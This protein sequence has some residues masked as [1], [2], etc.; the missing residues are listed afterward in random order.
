MALL[1]VVGM[2]A[3]N[4]VSRLPNLGQSL[5]DQGIHGFNGALVGCAA[6]VLSESSS[7]FDAALMAIFVA[8]GGGLTTVMIELWR[9]RFHRRGDPP[10]LTLP[11][12]LTTWGLMVLVSPRIPDSIETV[13]AAASTS[14][15]Q[16]L[17]LGI[18]HSFGQ[19]FLCSDL[20]SGWLVLLAVAVASPMAAA[21]GTCGALIGMITALASGT[22]PAAIAQGLWGYNGVLV[23]IALGGIFHAPGRR[24]LVIALIG[25]SLASLLQAMQGSWIGN[26]PPLTLSFVLTTWM[27]QGLAGPALP[28]LIPVALHAV[29]TTEE[30]RKR[31]LV[32]NELLGSFRQN[33]KQRIE[34]TLPSVGLEQPETERNSQMQHL[35]DQL[36]RNR[37][38]NLSLEELRHALAM[39]GASDGNQLRRTSSLNDQLAATMA[40]MDLNADGRINCNEFS[41]L[42]Q[43]L[44]RLR[45]GEERLLLYLM[46]VDT[47]GNDRLDHDELDRLLTSIGQPAL[48]SKEQALVFM[49]HE[50]SLSW[51]DF[52][53]RLLL[54]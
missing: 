20:A 18:P 50:Q 11:F 13:Q 46:P 22:D 49:D 23:A 25:V 10:A 17:A 27:M 33:L 42:I 45:Q 4:T 48:T 38:G 28:A 29:V 35:F 31:F 15:L 47:N 3:A 19:V 7:L 24:S 5:R 53:D 12:C 6:A 41:Q 39:E 54:S 16:A 43:R 51:H 52:V 37:D 8:L 30:H 2:A 26:L 36:D 9:R 1:A 32:A 34:G 40:S 44:Q 14:S 21:L